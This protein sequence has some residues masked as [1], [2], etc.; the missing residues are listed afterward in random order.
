METVS[1]DGLRIAYDS[2]GTG[3]PP[4]VFIHGAFEDRSYFALQ[5]AHLAARHRVIS[6]DLRG[7]GESDVP[8]AVAVEDF[9]ADVIAVADDAGIEDAVFCGHSMGGAVALIVAAARPELVRAVVMLDGTILF[10]EPVGRHANETLVPALATDHW[11]DALRG[12]F[13]RTL[14]PADP[15]DVRERVLSDMACATPEFA[16]SFFAS[17]FA[18]DY[19]DALANVDRPL[20]YVHAKAPADLRRLAELR[21][22]AMI[23]RVVGSGHYVMLS[24]AEQVNAMIDRFLEATSGSGSARRGLRAAAGDQALAVE[25]A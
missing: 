25:Q 9:A 18:S 6:L 15:P 24:A 16:R 14:D 17:L 2:L 7:H 19:A 1:A 11:L 4:I 21:P 12:Y 22:D 20:L 23:G 5:Q 3:A 10:P 8:A 13:A